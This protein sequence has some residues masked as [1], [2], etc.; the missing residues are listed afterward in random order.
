MLRPVRLPTCAMIAL[1]MSSPLEAGQRGGRGGRG[2]AQTRGGGAGGRG[3]GGEAAGSGAQRWRRPEADVKRSGPS[4]SS[5][6]PRALNPRRRKRPV[7]AMASCGA[8]M[9]AWARMHRISSMRRASCAAVVDDSRNFIEAKADG[10]AWDCA[11]STNKR[12]R[13]C[14]ARGRPPLALPCPAQICVDCAHVPQGAERASGGCGGDA[15]PRFTPCLLVAMTDASSPDVAIDVHHPIPS[16]HQPSATG[17]GAGVGARA[18]ARASTTR[19]SARWPPGSRSSAMRFVGVAG[20]VGVVAV[21]VGGLAGV[22]GVVQLGAAAAAA[23]A[24]NRVRAR[25]MA[26]AVPPRAGE[27]RSPHRPPTAWMRKR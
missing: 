6:A 26:S 15:P 19:R 1:S 20:V 23:A 4:A 27:R 3:G 12:T 5:P 11:D 22:G 17:V 10:A 18:S 9:L 2:A 21:L 25:R 16:P 24:A 14:P 8:S 13:W 7:R